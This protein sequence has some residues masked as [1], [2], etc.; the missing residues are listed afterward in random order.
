MLERFFYFGT[1][2]LQDLSGFMVDAHEERYRPCGVINIIR[3]WQLLRLG[4]ARSDSEMYPGNEW[5]RKH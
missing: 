4:F 1:G 3:D 5:A 2:I